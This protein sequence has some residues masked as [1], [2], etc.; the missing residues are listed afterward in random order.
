MQGEGSND[1]R[2]LLIP[3]VDRIHLRLLFD[4]DYPATPEDLDGLLA[5]PMHETGSD[6]VV[7]AGESFIDLYLRMSWTIDGVCRLIP[8]PGSEFGKQES[9]FPFGVVAGAGLAYLASRR[10]PDGNGFEMTARAYGTDHAEAAGV[11]IEQI[12]AWDEAG[13]DQ[14]PAPTYRYWP[15]RQEAPADTTVSGSHA[16]VKRHGV[17]TVS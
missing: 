1:G 9:W 11:L 13:R 8:D 17:L 3:D 7:A 12:R 16:L 6:V 5:T 2:T 14:G 10:V 4:K 15:N